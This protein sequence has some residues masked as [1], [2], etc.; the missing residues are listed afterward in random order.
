MLSGLE[1]FSWTESTSGASSGDT[2]GHMQEDYSTKCKAI[3]I[4]HDFRPYR[5]NSLALHW[6]AVESTKES[7]WWLLI[8]I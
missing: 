7:Q 2:A 6:A 1:G 5:S 3:W 8:K 4:A